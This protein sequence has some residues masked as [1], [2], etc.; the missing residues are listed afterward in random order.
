MD[1]KSYDCPNCGAKLEFVPDK[2][3]F[4]CEYC[5]SEFDENQINE[6][7]QQVLDNEREK[8][9]RR[10]NPP[11]EAPLTSEE[12]RANTEFEENTRL[13]QC[14][15]C[16]AQIVA[17]NNTAASFCYYCHNPVILKGR[18][19]GMFRPSKVL[20]FAF[21]KEKAIEY[22]N[23]WAGNKTFV[24]KDLVS[25]KQIEKMTGLY[26]PFWIADAT[27]LTN[28]SAVGKKVKTWTQGNYRYTNTKEYEVLRELQTHYYGVPGDG[29]KKIEDALMESIEPYDYKQ[30]KDFD[31]AY[32]SGFFADKYDV[33]KEEMY[34]RIYDRMRDNNNES[35]KKLV[36][37]YTYVN[38]EQISNNT[39]QL[40]WHYMLLP[41]WFM[42]FNYQ[43]KVWEYAINGQ[44]GKIA[45]E[46]PID[47]KKLRLHQFLISLLTAAAIL[48]A[49]YFLGGG[50][51]AV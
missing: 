51:N 44:T 5:L 47:P 50:W 22:F 40:K 39:T 27:T 10:N 2:Q 24:P 17:D 31:M 25:E 34:P 36:T 8:N 14:P 49:G 32:L 13:Y 30:L 43:G 18:V 45:G 16:G 26:V 41:V 11:P 6:L 42:T 3:K 29:S 12:E 37:G 38:H 19:Q 15:T 7:A 4:C 28:Y 48:A 35:V 33:T 9:E 46:L 1:V 20:P 21:G 23:E